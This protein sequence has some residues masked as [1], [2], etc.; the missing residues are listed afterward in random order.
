MTTP[1]ALGAIRSTEDERD[2]SLAQLPGFEA[3]IVL[4]TSYLPK[5]A[6][7]ILDQGQAPA[8]VGFSAAGDTQIR[9]DLDYSAEAV[10]DGLEAYELAKR[11][12]GNTSDGTSIRQEINVRLQTGL[13][14]VKDILGA[15]GVGAREK[16]TAYARLNS[17][18]DIKTAIA[19]YGSAWIAADWAQAWFTPGPRNTLR[20]FDTAAGGHAFLFVGYD[21]SHVNFDGTTGAFLLQNSWGASWADGGRVWFPYNYLTPAIGWEAWRTTTAPVASA[22]V[23][24]ASGPDVKTA[25]LIDAVRLIA[26]DGS[27]VI[28]TPRVYQTAE[29]GHIVAG[30]YQGPAH[31]VTQGGVTLYLL[32]RN[33]KLS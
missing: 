30:R 6:W 33:A 20:P 27:T 16:I 31:S 25:T 29:A 14:V 4:P 23:F 19:T 1:Y 9:T 17:I 10:F 32:D 5:V 22:A 12:D 2:Y 28:P 15:L 24:V 3:P 13:R 11:L 7:T 26:A 18:L 21:D 8:C